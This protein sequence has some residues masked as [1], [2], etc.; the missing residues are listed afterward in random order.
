MADNRNTGTAPFP[1]HKVWT[2]LLLAGL[3]SVS[4]GPLRGAPTDSTS[5]PADPRKQRHQVGIDLGSDADPDLLAPT[6]PVGLDRL[7]E[8]DYRFVV[9]DDRIG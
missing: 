2:I 8:W 4:P 5:L 1:F 7:L 3:L 9:R 6:A